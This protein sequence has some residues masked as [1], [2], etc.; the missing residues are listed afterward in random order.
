MLLRPVHWRLAVLALVAATLLVV[1]PTLTPVI[2]Q[3]QMPA[4][5]H[6]AMQAEGARMASVAMPMHAHLHA[7]PH[8]MPGRGG[9]GGHDDGAC[10]YCPLLA[11][12]LQWQAHATFAPLRMPLL[13]MRVR[14][15][16]RRASAWRATLGARGPP[17]AV[18][19]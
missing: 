17:A 12:L 10:A 9:H 15:A 4:T 6:A 14:V 11:G 7:A 1:M 8:G 18:V 19:A 3:P 5:A 13:P 16:T 2:T